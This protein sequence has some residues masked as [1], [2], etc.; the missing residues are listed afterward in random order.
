MEGIKEITYEVILDENNIVLS[1]AKISEQIISEPIDEIIEIK[2]KQINEEN[3]I[4][5]FLGM[6]LWLLSIGVVLGSREILRKNTLFEKIKS[7]QKF[8][9]VYYI[10]YVLFIIPSFVDM[11]II[12]VNLFKLK[13]NNITNL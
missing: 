7:Q 8:K 13:R 3:P 11:I 6:I 2:S 10:V 5:S 4:S 9:I 1:R 12:I